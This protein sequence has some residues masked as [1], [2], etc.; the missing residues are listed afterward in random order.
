MKLE[1][2]FQGEGEQ[3]S[4]TAR[5]I[6]KDAPIIILEEAASVL[7]TENKYKVLEAIDE[8]TGNKMVVMIASRMK[9]IRNADH[10]IVIEKGELKQEGAHGELI[11]QDRICARFVNEREKAMG[12]KVRQV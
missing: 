9:S 6:L 8:L 10:I 5:A 2:A 3:R 4:S 1:E 12:W 7:D 11:K